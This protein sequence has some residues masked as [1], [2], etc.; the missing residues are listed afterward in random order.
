MQ[1]TVWYDKA[2][3]YLLLLGKVCVVKLFSDNFDT[4]FG[5][6]YNAGAAKTNDEQLSFSH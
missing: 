3:T 4:K 6:F 5:T 1:F 2:L